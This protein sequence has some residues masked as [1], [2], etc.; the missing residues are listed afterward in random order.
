MKVESVT[1]FAPFDWPKSDKLRALRRIETAVEL[2]GVLSST[3]RLA[4][5]P[6]D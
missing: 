1:R 2:A 5:H 3:V 6:F 4:G